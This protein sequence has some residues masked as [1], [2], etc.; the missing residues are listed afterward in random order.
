MVLNLSDWSCI[1]DCR[2]LERMA[3]RSAY[4][5]LDPAKNKYIKYMRHIRWIQEY[6]LAKADKHHIPRLENSN[7]DRGV[8]IAH[9]TVMGCVQAERI[10]LSSL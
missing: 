1:Y 7:A 9:L 4:M 2:H 5:T 3:V 8:G 10:S 6:L